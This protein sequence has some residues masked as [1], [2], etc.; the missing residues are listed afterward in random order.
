MGRKES[1]Q[2]NKTTGNFDF[3]FNCTLVGQNGLD[4][5]TIYIYEKL[6][7]DVV[8]AVRSTGVELLDFFTP[9]FSCMF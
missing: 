5:K 2:T 6:G 9:V 8:S 3:L 7:P 1:N 4:L